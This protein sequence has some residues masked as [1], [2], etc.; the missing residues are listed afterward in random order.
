M[1]NLFLALFLLTNVAALSQNDKIYMHNG[2]TVEGT[3]VRV[4]E[5]TL[6]F[7]HANEDAEQTAGK[8]AVEKIV[9]G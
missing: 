6:I 7:K 1:K 4:A 9:Y 2:K 5:F 8:Y 3:V